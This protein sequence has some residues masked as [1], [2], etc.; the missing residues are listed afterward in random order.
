MSD[1]HILGDLPAAAA[2]AL[3]AVGVKCGP[4]GAVALGVWP[5]T[6]GPD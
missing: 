6:H 2:A 4:R 1:V 3:E 5:C